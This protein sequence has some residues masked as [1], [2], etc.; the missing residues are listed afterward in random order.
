MPLDHGLGFHDQQRVPP[1]V[2]EPPHQD[3]EDPIAVVDLR[4][5]HGA[6]EYRDLLAKSEILD[7]QARSISDQRVDEPEK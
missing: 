4:A 7:G 1:A 3:P 2:E 6:L 5:L